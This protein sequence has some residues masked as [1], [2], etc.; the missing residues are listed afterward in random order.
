M[1]VQIEQVD[2]AAGVVTDFGD[3]L[4]CIG[5][6]FIFAVEDGD[7]FD[8]VQRGLYAEGGCRAAGAQ[9]GH[10]FA[11]DVDAFFFERAHISSAIG[12]VAGQYA[13]VVHHGIHRANQLCSRRE[14]VQIL[15]NL[16]FVRHR[17][18]TAAQF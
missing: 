6:E 3:G 7:R 2:L 17:D 11:D 10:L 16:R 4:F 18:V 13:I 12:D 14:F 15:A 1:I 5:E 8:A 9:H